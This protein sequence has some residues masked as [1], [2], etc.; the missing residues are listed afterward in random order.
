[1]THVY[2]H[3]LPCT[4]L[5][6]RAP[7]RARGKASI[8]AKLRNK[9]SV[10]G[11]LRQ[12]GSLKLLFPRSTDLGLQTVLVNTAG[13]I[14]GGDRFELEAKAAAGTELTVTTQAA[15]RAY[16]S[17]PGETGLIRTRLA[18]DKNASLNWLPQ[19]TILFQGC[20]LDRS[21][22][23]DVHNSAR[24]LLCETV[25]F[26]RAAMGERL[27]QAQ[28]RDCIEIRRAGVPLFHDAM[29][30]KGDIAAHLALSTT[31]NGAGALAT[32]VYMSPDAAG[33]LAPVRRQL[34]PTAGAS[35]IGNDL[36]ILRALAPDS[37]LLRRLLMP[38]LA[39]LHQRPLPRTWMI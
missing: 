26:G 31:A 19:E 39:L 28:L 27:T 30:L 4:A 9:R 24:L 14:T 17:Q 7:P 22:Q 8:A 37:Y 20:N 32:V 13:G 35:L 6:N 16:R 18:A 2:S 34:G 33:R 15:E 23:V 38:I 10:I 36:L 21:L 25:I 3:I 12:A 11:D 5:A 1:M 29:E